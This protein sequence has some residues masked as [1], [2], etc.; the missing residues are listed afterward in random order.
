MHVDCSL[1]VTYTDLARLGP[2]L[3]FDDVLL[4]ACA[5]VRPLDLPDELGGEK[6]FLI[7]LLSF[8][9]LTLVVVLGF[10][11]EGG[12]GFTPTTLMLVDDSDEEPSVE[13]LEVVELSSERLADDVSRDAR[14]FC[15]FLAD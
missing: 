5:V 11:F 15:S 3:L 14:N 8:S 12:A 10:L 9:C 4:L 7:V 6:Y 1:G 2:L 13:L